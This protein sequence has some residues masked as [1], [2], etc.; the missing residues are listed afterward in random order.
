MLGTQA[1]P[2]PGL[3]VY[4]SSPR[5]SYI[6]CLGFISEGGRALLPALWPSNLTH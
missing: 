3:Y 2:L 5:V 6:Q 1:H 4:G